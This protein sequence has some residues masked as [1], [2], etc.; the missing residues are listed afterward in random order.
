MSSL[1][2]YSHPEL[3]VTEGLVRQGAGK[4]FPYNVE[5][6]DSASGLYGPGAIYCWYMLL[7]SVLATWAFCRAGRDGF[8]K[9]GLSSDL[10]GALAYPVFAATD[11]LVQSIRMQGMGQRALAIFCLRYP[12]TD[13]KILGP[14]DDAEID[15][16][17]VPPDIL[18]LGQHVINITGPLTIC[19]TAAS[20]LSLLIILFCCNFDVFDIGVWRPI[21]WARWLIYAVWGYIFLILT[22]FHLSLGSLGASFFLFLYETMLPV[23]LTTVYIF[24][25]TLGILLIAAFVR[26]ALAAVAKDSTLLALPSILTVYSNRLSMTPDLGI[27]VSERDQLATL[28]VGVFTLAL[29]LF[30]I[31]WNR[32]DINGREVVEEEIQMPA[33]GEI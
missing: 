8:R 3:Q 21:P 31:I 23:G 33:A 9:P 19:Y 13:L 29:T 20:F 6:Y 18:D 4:L 5:F 16:N 27:R 15:L 7:A 12:E 26:L 30:D 17:H 11:L 22:I 25:F 32:R 28:I 14:F 24:A 10:L 2:N 1:C